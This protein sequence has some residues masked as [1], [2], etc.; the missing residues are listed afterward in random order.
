[1]LDLIQPRW[2][3]L[4]ACALWVLWLAAMGCVEPVDPDDDAA[5]D[6]AADDDG[7]DD[8]GS[9][10]D[11]GDDDT[12]TDPCD[13]FALLA[14]QV[15][16]ARLL[17]TMTWLTSYTRR[18]SWAV[19]EEILDQLADDLEEAGA[20][21]HYH[22]Y[23]YEQNTHHNLVAMVPASA[24][25]SPST[26][27]LVI[28]AHVDSTSESPQYDAP[29]ADDNASGVAAVLETAMLLAAC[30]LPTRIDFVFFTNEEVG[31]VGS[32]AYAGDAHDNEEA[33]VGMIAAD[34][35][36]YGAAGEDLDLATKPWTTW[37]PEAYA[38]ASDLYTG[39]ETVTV[40]DDHCG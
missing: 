29:G 1:V 2:T 12:A 18:D 26:P 35:L 15:D 11:G 7:G 34:M 33:I 36:A 13:D 14:D 19:Q 3:A 8:D 23:S 30:E 40:L 17:D 32:Y 28:G 27:H 24:D 6:D 22:A 39:I 9:D 16:P 21:V 25:P 37:L 31:T 10:D 38:E 5:D 4:S 20:A